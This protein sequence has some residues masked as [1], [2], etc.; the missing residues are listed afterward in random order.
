MNLPER[1]IKGRIKRIIDIIKETA[2]NGFYEIDLDYYVDI[3]FTNDMID[4]IKSAFNKDELIFKDNMII[5]NMDS[6]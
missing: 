2:D 6:K 3:Y 5:I 4:E 1:V